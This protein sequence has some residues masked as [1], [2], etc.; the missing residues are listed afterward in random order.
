MNQGPRPVHPQTLLSS[1]NLKPRVPMRQAPQAPHAPS[2][3]NRPEEGEATARSQAQPQVPL[4]VRSS[5]QGPRTHSRLAS[6]HPG[7]TGKHLWS[8]GKHLWFAGKQSWLASKHPWV[9]PPLHV[10]WPVKPGHARGAGFCRSCWKTANCMS[11]AG[12]TQCATA[13]SRARMQ[14]GRHTSPCASACRLNGVSCSIISVHGSVLERR[15]LE[16][17]LWGTM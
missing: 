10:V 17:V 13:E 4:L 14:I 5:Q 15:T 11:A 1:T 7:L 8:G 16:H 6:E 9:A 3:S 12:A 2:P